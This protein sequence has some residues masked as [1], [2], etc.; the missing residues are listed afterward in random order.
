M[1]VQPEHRTNL[2]LETGRIKNSRRVRLIILIITFS[3]VVIDV[4]FVVTGWVSYVPST[5][6]FISILL[7]IYALYLSS[8]SRRRIELLNSLD[9][10]EFPSSG[11]HVIGE[12]S[13]RTEI[14]M[15]GMSIRSNLAS[16][17]TPLRLDLLQ[18]RH[19]QTDLVFLFNQP[20]VD[21]HEFFGRKQE[22]SK[23][24]SRT[25]QGA[26]TSII[27]P[28]RIGKTWLISYLRLVAE[29]QLGSSYCIGYLD[30]TSPSCSTKAGFIQK[31]LV[32]LD[33]PQLIPSNQEPQMKL[34]ENAIGVLKAKNKTPVL[35]IDEFEGFQDE[36]EFDLQFFNNLRALALNGL[37][38]IVAS[39]IP[40]ANLL[41]NKINGP[42]P[43]FNIFF[44][45]KLQPFMEDEAAE[46]IRVKSLQAG[47]TEDEQDLLWSCGIEDQDNQKVWPPALL[48][49]AGQLII[50]ER[51]KVNYKPNDAEYCEQ[52]KQRLEDRYRD[53]APLEIALR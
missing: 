31:A 5:L 27:G 8:S 1:P 42:S 47:F 13:A 20:L 34:L 41:R 23:L 9:Q 18:V 45:I 10:R 21:A 15:P 39:G 32:A 22:F 3:F 49:F 37:V 48:Q 33:C 24:I 52:F 30:A 51:V 53:I 36:E 12:I 17:E 44:N 35:C 11:L 14:P 38:L 7:A 29:E 43:L 25:L 50:E 28:R 4:I 19:S 16:A 6:A 40:L 46:F 26:P 2:Q